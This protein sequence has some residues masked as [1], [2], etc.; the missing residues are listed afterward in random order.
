MLMN[1]EHEL[2]LKNIKRNK[3]KITVLRIAILVVFIAV[4][5]IA[6]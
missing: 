5:E 4:W 6:A 3:V 2:Y 1:E